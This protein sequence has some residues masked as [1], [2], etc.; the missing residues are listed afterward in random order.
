L[1]KLSSWPE[2]VDE[3]IDLLSYKDFGVLFGIVVGK[4]SEFLS[5]LLFFFNLVKLF[6]KSFD[7]LFK[8]PLGLGLLFRKDLQW[9]GSGLIIVILWKMGGICVFGEVKRAVEGLLVFRMRGFMRDF[10]FGLE[11]RHF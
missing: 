2:A 8:D 11:L 5:L 7:F 10:V 6:F 4:I 1:K 9:R 3:M